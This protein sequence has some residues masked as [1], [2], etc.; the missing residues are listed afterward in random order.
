MGIGTPLAVGA[1]AAACELAAPSGQPLRP[2]V[3]FTGDGA[4][5]VYLAELNSIALTQLPLRMGVL[6]DQAWGTEH[7]GQQLTFGRAINV[8]LGEIHYDRIARGFGLS[9]EQ[10]RHPREVRPTLERLFASPGPALLDCWVDREAG[11]ERKQDP[12][13]LND[14]ARR[15]HR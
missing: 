9:A 8:D 3:L 15:H 5:G 11:R 6:N 4:F 14:P 13:L 7:D 10:V 1:A 12:R 2:V